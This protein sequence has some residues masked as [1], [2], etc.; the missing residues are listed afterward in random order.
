ME[1]N[2]CSTIDSCGKYV[3]TLFNNDGNHPYNVIES[4]VELGHPLQSCMSS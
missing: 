1:F 3:S 4:L 2:Y